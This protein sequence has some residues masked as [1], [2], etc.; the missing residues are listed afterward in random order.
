MNDLMNLEIQDEYDKTMTN[1][2]DR[3]RIIDE[4]VCLHSQSAMNSFVEVHPIVQFQSMKDLLPNINKNE[5]HISN[6]ELSAEE[7]L[8]DLLKSHPI[9]ERTLMN[10]STK[11][12]KRISPNLDF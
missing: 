7:D 8:K 10:H 2:S 5:K 11:D 3:F 9:A 6:E 12:W 1:Q 4:E